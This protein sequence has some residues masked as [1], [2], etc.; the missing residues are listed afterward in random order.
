M[1]ESFLIK[2]IDIQDAMHVKESEAQSLACGAII[3]VWYM[4]KSFL[5]KPIDMQ[6]AMQVK[7]SEAQS[8]ACGTFI[9]V[10]YIIKSFLTKPIDIQ[11]AMYVKE[12]GEVQP[13]EQTFFEFCGQQ[14]YSWSR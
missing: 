7:E 9:K 4:I 1:I 13:E 3:E 8:L 14:W 5:I 12:S 2:P 6:D 10:W 11:D